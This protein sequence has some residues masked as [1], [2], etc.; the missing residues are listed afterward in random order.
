MS[1][2]C[3]V[4]TYRP[5]AL[6]SALAFS[7]GDTMTLAGLFKD[8]QSAFEH[9]P[10]VETSLERRGVRGLGWHYVPDENHARVLRLLADG[11]V[12]LRASRTSGGVG[13]ALVTTEAEVHECWPTQP[14]AFVAAAPYLDPTVPLNFSG[15]VF[16]DGS[17][18]LHPPSLQ[19]IGIPSC[20]DRPFGY[21]GND[22]GAARGLATS[23]LEELDDLGRAVGGWLHEERYLGVFGV[24]ALL[25]EGNVLFTEVNA[26][27]Q[28]SSG[29][30]SQIATEQNLPDLFLD[31][32]AATLGV[33]PTGHGL[34]MPEWARHQPDVSQIVVHN[35]TR[36]SVTRSDGPWPELPRRAR[37]AQVATVARIDPG[38][39]LCRAT[40]PRTVTTTGF[41]IDTA[42]ANCA[43]ALQA[44][45]Q[46]VVNQFGTT[47]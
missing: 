28:G 10:W 22:F 13:I 46:P 23:I 1:G 3:V 43:T 24:D 47:P 20:T 7:M 38:A 25:Y 27:F 14:D 39:T 21:C 37:L 8:R 33:E 17:V 19:L 29:L 36:G 18:R 42:V 44:V 41:E 11:P 32:L 45:F 6:V 16:A 12:V 9:K 34:S 30:S 5:S 31:H 4:M 40:F 15:V 2:P 26:R 35:T